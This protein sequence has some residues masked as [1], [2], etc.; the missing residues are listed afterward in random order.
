MLIKDLLV[1][2]KSN[3]NIAIQHQ[4]NSITYEEWYQ[5]SSRLS[6]I[7]SKIAKKN[8]KNIAIFLP[9]SI[10][11]AIAYFGITFSN[12]VI[13]PIGA[14][15]TLSEVKS[16]MKY[17][18]IDIIITKKN[19]KEFFE[20]LEKEYEYMFRVIYIDDFC[21][22]IFNCN[23]D[24]LDKTNS[25]GDSNSED[26]VALLLHTSGT[27]SN[28]KRVM[29][30]HK[31]LISNVESNITYLG[32]SC[33]EKTLIS[34]PMHF[35]YCNTSQFL[36]H[37]YLG[38]YMCILKE[39]FMPKVFFE[40]IQNKKITNYTGVP[41]T[42]FMLLNYKYEKL[43]DYSSLRFVCIGGSKI[44]SKELIEISNRYVTFDVIYTYGQSEASTR[45]TALMQKDLEK[46]KDSVGLPIPNVK[47]KIVNNEGDIL[48]PYQ[49][50]E[51]IING[52][53]VMRGYY[54]NE[55]LTEQTIIDGWLHSGDIGYIDDDGY[56][57]V[58]G[59]IKNI[60]ISGGINIYPE[61]IEEILIAHPNIKKVRVE[62][63][64]HSLLGEIVIAKL[65]LY[66]N[67]KTENFKAFCSK[68]LSDYKIPKRF[69]IVED[70]QE[71][72][73]GKIKRKEVQI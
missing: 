36:S 61:E 38:A 8:S 23:S 37:I 53:N 20:K 24:Y 16:T 62:S 10:E 49:C 48:P 28:P 43:Y 44:S 50:G 66:D 54:K 57:Y 72:Y 32:L 4:N 41:S 33:D 18:E 19:R 22:E 55:L 59:R 58:K 7:I 29:L 40:T 9:N 3:S 68:Y 21:N 35:G 5:N 46:R 27:M 52:N 2:Q 42:F 13:V 70:L 31:N 17:C 12:K 63:E 1:R 15:S 26:D 51:I 30:S 14:K 56:L 11:Y 67:K 64:V 65:V 60:I 69:E 73:N 34:M 25:Y 71:T 39:P 6:E 45:V 47:I